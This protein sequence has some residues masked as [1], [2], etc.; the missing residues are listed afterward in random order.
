MLV[1]RRPRVRGR[2]RGFLVTTCAV[3]ALGLAHSASAL[4]E[5][6]VYD[7]GAKSVTATITPGSQATLKVDGSAIWFGFSPAACG[8]ATTANT[9]SISISGSA[10]T[11]ERLVLDQ[12]TGV[13]GPGATAEFNIPEI[14]IST[15][16]G[17]ATDTMVVYGTA[18]DDTIAPGQL[19]IALNS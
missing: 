6:C 11:N 12:A 1:S 7:A 3:A 16:L 5:S 15:S 4:A 8:G 2:L 18:G 10:G 9:D 14:E 17:D 13:F 19:G